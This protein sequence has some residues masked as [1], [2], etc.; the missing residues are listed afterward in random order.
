MDKSR[1]GFTVLTAFVFIFAIV[2]IGI[3]SSYS[4]DEAE[5]FKWDVSFENI[6]VVGGSISEY[7]EPTLINKTSSVKDIRF[8]VKTS[9]DTIN[10][11]INT[12]NNGTVDAKVTAILVT[13]PTCNNKTCND[14]EYSLVYEDGNTV[15]K[16][17]ILK[18]NSGKNM[19]LKF[20]Y[21]GNVTE[22]IS[23]KDINVSIDYAVVEG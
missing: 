10:Y 2:V 8:E 7:D 6:D 13:E 18:A 21:N 9:G 19:Y 11:K 20:K 12:L 4:I 22:S 16:G 17:D 1:F 23:V 5:T 3:N 14:L 15:K